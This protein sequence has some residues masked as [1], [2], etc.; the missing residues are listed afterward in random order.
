VARRGRGEGSIYQRKDG[1]WT[2]AISIGDGRRQQFYGKTRREVQTQLTAALRAR[3]QGLVIAASRQRL[4][5]Y[6]EEWLTA[7]APNVRRSTWITDAAR[8]RNHIIPALGRIALGDL[9]PAHVEQFMSAK[10]ADGLSPQTVIHLRGILRRALQRA[11]RHGG[12]AR[13]AAGLADPPRLPKANVP[14]P[15]SP[16]E[17]RM[18][19]HAIRGDRLEALWIVYLTTGLRRGQALGL[20][21]MD[22]DLEAGTLW[23]RRAVLRL[24]TELRTDEEAKTEE[25]SARK[26]LARMAVDALRAH[27][28]AAEAAGRYT[29]AGLVFQTT[30]GTP[31]EPRNVNR[32]FDR[33]LAKAGLR[34]VRLHDLR[35]SFGALLLENDERS[36]EPG[37]HVRVVMELLGHSQLSETLKRYTKVRE[38]LKRQALD[39]LDTLLRSADSAGID[40]QS[41]DQS[42]GELLSDVLSLAVWF[43][44]RPDDLNS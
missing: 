34:H 39:R 23:P 8:V 12:L 38:G 2:A 44:L 27:R 4:D 15:Y 37:T 24:S 7:I 11:V 13:N 31:I 35:E 18:L 19:L 3:D 17:A 43:G 6:L 41:D 29:P 30:A 36:G 21:W 26:P 40:D 28:E 14:E 10:L 22:V 9:T 42:V 32:S 16:G 33:L 25:S 1:R 20:R 5:A